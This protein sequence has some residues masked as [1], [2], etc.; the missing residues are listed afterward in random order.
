LNSFR[1]TT[2]VSARISSIVALLK[3]KK[4]YPKWVYNCQSAKSLGENKD[5]SAYSYTITKTP[6]P[7]RSRDSV[8]YST[9]KQN[10][11]TKEVIIS[12]IAKPNYHPLKNGLVRIQQLKGQWVLTPQKNGVIKVTTEIMV[13]PGGRLPKWLVN[14]FA[15]NTPFNTLLGLRKMVN[16]PIYK[17]IKLNY[18][19]D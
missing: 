13:D 12:L 15:I 1:G 16:S 18:I 17:N 6:W 9:L 7:F 19:V 5:L 14:Q 8:V 2:L 10:K 4:N 3:D 11:K